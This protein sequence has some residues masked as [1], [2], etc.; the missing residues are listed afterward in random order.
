MGACVYAMQKPI[1]VCQIWAKTMPFCHVSFAVFCNAKPHPVWRFRAK[2]KFAKISNKIETNTTCAP[3]RQPRRVFLLPFWQKL[4]P[5]LRFFTLLHVFC[6]RLFALHNAV[7]SV[8]SFCH[9]YRHFWQRLV[10]NCCTFCW[11]HLFFPNSCVFLFAHPFAGNFFP[12]TVGVVEFFVATS[13][14]ALFFKFRLM[15][16][17]CLV[18]VATSAIVFC[19]WCGV[20]LLQTFARQNARRCQFALCFLCSHNALFFGCLFCTKCVLC[21]FWFKVQFCCCCIAKHAFCFCLSHKFKNE[22]IFKLI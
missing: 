12:S 5:V 21:P 3:F 18:N 14:I 17:L 2:C 1:P 13:A 6:T 7:A 10:C 8:L 19:W 22:K 9:T 15:P 16:A 20:W 11:L 4:P